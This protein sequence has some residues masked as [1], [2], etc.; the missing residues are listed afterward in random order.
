MRLGC[1]IAAAAV[2]VSAAAAPRGVP[3]S[4]EAAY[5]G[6]TTFT[7]LDTSKTIEA[8]RV[9]DDFCDCA[10]GS[11]EP[12]TSA[13]PQGKFFCVNKG[14]RSRFIPSSLVNDGVCDCCDGSDE[15][16]GRAACPNTCDADG[17][18]WREQQAEA[19]R[20]A[21][22]GARLR[23]QYASEGTDAAT[24]RAAK[25]AALTAAVEEAKT[26]QAAAE[27]ALAV[28]E[29]EEKTERQKRAASAA[30][31][32]RTAI[33]S[34]L[35]IEGYSRD[36]LLDL[37]RCDS[38]GTS[39]W[40]QAAVSLHPAQAGDVAAVWRHGRLAATQRTQFSS[41]CASIVPLFVP[42]SPSSSAMETRL[43]YRHPHSQWRHASFVAIVIHV[44]YR[45]CVLSP[46]PAVSAACSSLR[47]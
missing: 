31:E 37:V 36:E 17:R 19:I 33:A 34:A 9:N 1:L 45:V 43:L 47:T 44:H 4:L 15:W 41:P 20:K 10:D 6:R 46:C 5:A 32:G 18:A 12:G 21:E 29:D 13:C 11:D 28:A 7:C 8:S 40:L 25:V 27:R 22:E 16:A 30:T 14:A 35:R 26:A 42:S 23:L 2:A 3:R 39:S 24:Q 38:C